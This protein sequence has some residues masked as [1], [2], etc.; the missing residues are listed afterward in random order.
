MTLG[1]VLLIN[2]GTYAELKA[3]RFLN[4]LLEIQKSSAIKV[5][6]FVLSKFIPKPT[7]NCQLS[8]KSGRDRQTDRQEDYYTFSR[9]R[10]EG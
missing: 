3:S 6:N 7:V 10:A 1:G 4:K 2:G 5:L 9:M 8:P